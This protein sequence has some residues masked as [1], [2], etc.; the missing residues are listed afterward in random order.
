MN[1]L[2]VALLLLLG[3][4]ETLSAQNANRSGF[5]LEAGF[6]GTI[7]NTPRKGFFISNNRIMNLY[8]AGPAVDFG[9]GYRFRTATHWAYEVK[10]EGQTCL[11]NPVN[12]LVGRFLPVGFRYTSVEFWRNFSLYGH[13]NL[14][15]AIAVNNGKI[16]AYYREN[17]PTSVLT[18]DM[19]D[20]AT[21]NGFKGENAFGGAYSL[22]IGVN[23]TTHFYAEA[24]FNG[25]WM[26]G[27]WGRNGH[28]AYHWGMAGAILGYRF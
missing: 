13:F 19:D 21:I 23:I 1:R 17:I 16:S 2:L 24:C 26:F 27:C 8:N 28:G 12:A 15:G 22:G 20:A 25:Q 4:A 3:M 5:F 6:G 9:L 14:G 18:P 7:G 10:A 11:S